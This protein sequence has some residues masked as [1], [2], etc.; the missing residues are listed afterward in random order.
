MPRLTTALIA[1]LLAGA[2]AV[3]IVTAVRVLTLPKAG[4]V[5]H[6]AGTHG[7][8]LDDLR[9][10]LNAL[11]I[12]QADGT[13]QTL[14]TRNAAAGL[15]FRGASYWTATDIASRRETYLD[16]GALLAAVLL[17][18]AAVVAAAGRLTAQAR[19][20]PAPR[21]ARGAT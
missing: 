12:Q 11:G 6:A 15:S 2:L 5:R 21:T 10:T 16:A 3:S 9:R 18:S 7:S 8:A 13:I 17:F 19:A 14:L 1:I 4:S 20:R